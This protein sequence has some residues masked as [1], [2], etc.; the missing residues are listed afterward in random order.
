MKT[1]MNISYKKK[2]TNKKSKYYFLYYKM[3]LLFSIFILQNFETESFIRNLINGSSEINM[4]IK[5]NGIQSL[6]NNDFKI[7]PFEVIVN[8][9]KKI[10]VIRHV[11]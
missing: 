3:M 2:E 10:H 4:V 1:K 11:F 5:G 7:Y 6:L 9:K 8:E